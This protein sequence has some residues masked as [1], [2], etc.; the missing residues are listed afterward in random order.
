MNIKIS[1]LNME[2]S[3]LLE[4]HTR[5]KLERLFELLRSEVDSTPFL[6]E[7]V[8]RANALHPHHSVEF[9]LRTK[10]FDLNAH[11]EGADMYVAVD[12]TIDKMAMLVKKDKEKLQD[13]HQKQDNEKRR[14]MK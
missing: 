10:H 5:Q 12:D 7:I 6:V 1:F 2:H 8:L 9:H 4:Q 3:D 11:E 14:F 13:K